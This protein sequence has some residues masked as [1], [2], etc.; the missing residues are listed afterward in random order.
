[1][2]HAGLCGRIVQGLCPQ[3]AEG[4]VLDLVGQPLHVLHLCIGEL[5]PVSEASGWALSPA[6]AGGMLACLV[7]AENKDGH[8]MGEEEHSGYQTLGHMQDICREI[9]EP[10]GRNLRSK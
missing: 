8:R 3:E 7:L 2:L 10:S 5:G 1:M 4:L 6:V 9:P